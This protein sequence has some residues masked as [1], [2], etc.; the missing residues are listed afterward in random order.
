M[1]MVNAAF[2]LP[3][4]SPP[5]APSRAQP[6]TRA[7][8][9]AWGFW[10]SLG[11]GLLALAIG[12]FAIVIHA[13]AWKLTHPLKTPDAADAA[14]GAAAAAIIAPVV[15]VGVLAI[16]A[17]IR[18]QSLRDYFALNSASR[19]DFFLGV[20]VLLALNVVFEILERQF[21]IDF[22]SESVS[23]TYREA[24]LAGLLPMLWLA[25][26]IVAPV[27]EE[28]MFRGFLHRG[29]VP[30]WLGISGTIVL[31]SALWALMHQQYNGLTIFCVFLT[32]LFLGWIRQRSGS[33]G[34]TIVLHALHNLTVTVLVTIQIGW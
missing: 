6:D 5:Q 18:R 28:L 21:G 10:G 4:A 1:S 8:L 32:G 19:R 23:S 11:W 20:A 9:P 2:E 25:V 16:A 24:K 27:S 13:L 33:T 31:T 30:S 14:F 3:T 34:L 15:T 22:G 12:F 29:W 7:V 26:V 17:K